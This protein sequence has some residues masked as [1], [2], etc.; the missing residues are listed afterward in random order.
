MVSFDQRNQQVETQYNAGGDIHVHAASAPPPSLSREDRRNRRPAAGQSARRGRQTAATTSWSA[1]PPSSRS[2]W[3][4]APRPSSIR[5]TPL[6]PATGRSARPPDDVPSITAIFDASDEALLIL[7]AP[8]SGKTTA[9]L[10]LTRT[11]IGRAEK[12]ENLPLPVVFHLASLGCHPP[13]ARLLD[14]QRAWHP[15]RRPEGHRGHAGRAGADP[16]SPGRPRRGFDRH[17]AAC[18]A[19]INDHCEGRPGAARQHR[20]LLPHR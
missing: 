14:G 9:M 4:D 18:V 12:D 8:G 7:G 17:R 1:P 10:D 15:L 2:A 19:A 20:G 13:A 16:A 6:A 3:N 5:R 11:L